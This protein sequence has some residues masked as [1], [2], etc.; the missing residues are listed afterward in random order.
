MTKRVRLIGLVGILLGWATVSA[1][2]QCAS[3]SANLA[4]VIPQEYGPGAFSAAGKGVFA[5]NQHEGHFDN[6]IGKLLS[7]VTQEIG[8]QANLLPLASPSSGSIWD[9][10]LKTFVPDSSLGPIFGERAE[11]VGRHRLFIGFSYQ[12]LDFDKIDGV[13][14]HNFPAV[15]THAEDNNNDNP[16]KDCGIDSSKGQGSINGCAFVRDLIRTANSVDLKINQY[17]TYVT[18]GLTRHIDISAVIPVENV[19]MNFTSND[20][21]VLGTN[22]F[23]P[24][25][26]GSTDAQQTA[27]PHFDHLWVGCTNTKPASASALSPT[28][29]DHPFP[30]PSI[31][32]GGSKQQNSATGIGDI[33]A[34]VKWN[35]WHGEKAGIAAGLDVRFPTG[36]AL[37]YLGS[38][39]YGVKPFAIFSYRLGRLSPHVVAGYEWNSDSITAGDLISNTKGGV[40]SDFVYSAGADA[41]ITRWLTGSFDIVGERVFDTQTLSVT[42]QSFLAPCGDP[43]Q[44]SPIPPSCTAAPTPNTVSYNSLSPKSNTSY[45]I[46]NASMGIKV[47]PLPSLSNL[48]VTANVLVRLDDGGLHSKPAP[49][50]GL[51]YTF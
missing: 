24:A 49:L 4:C 42:T 19:R 29:L 48:V 46:T 18:F 51:G 7:P 50:I 6:S 45:S 13:T 37:N 11:T 12:F 47:R 14:L 17:T 5:N 43:Q 21:I 40:P 28:C 32:Q 25:P 41:R 39:S 34:R 22:G 1:Y 33:V 9:S 10:S 23:Y 27:F 26:P 15:F 16:G 35:V 3:S 38:G 44:T 31:T 2:A 8:R 30:D 36:D 20:T